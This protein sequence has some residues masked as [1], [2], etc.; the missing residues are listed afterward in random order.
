MEIVV[1]T[2]EVHIGATV[3]IREQKESVVDAIQLE[4]LE[5]LFRHIN[6]N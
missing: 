3:K 6:D 4:V 5:N 1:T 2:G